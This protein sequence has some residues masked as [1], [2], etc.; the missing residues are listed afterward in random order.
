MMVQSHPTTVTHSLPA[1]ALLNDLGIFW[2]LSIRWKIPVWISGKWNSIF[3]ARVCVKEDN[4]AGNLHSIW[5]SYL[6]FWD[7][8]LNSSPFRNSII[9]RF[10][11]PGNFRTIYPQFE[12]FVIFAWTESALFV[13]RKA[14][15]SFQDTY[16]ISLRVVAY[17]IRGDNSNNLWADEPGW[18]AKHVS[19]SHDHACVLRRNIQD[20]DGITR[21]VETCYADTNGKKRNGKNRSLGISGNQDKEW[22]SCTTCKPRNSPISLSLQLFSFP[23][24]ARLI[25]F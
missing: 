13:L 14:N 25:N 21:G 23:S 5:L 22:S 24:A 3:R 17:L 10:S 20:I 16:F 8:G 19:Y 4:L 7:F 15:L 11:F 2:A 9:C 1:L 18:R 12:T 6:N